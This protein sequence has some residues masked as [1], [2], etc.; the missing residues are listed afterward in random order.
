MNSMIGIINYILL[1]LHIPSDE[2]YDLNHQLQYLLDLP[3]D[4]QYE[5]NQHTRIKNYILL[6]LHVPSDEQY[7]NNH[8]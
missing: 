2:Q 5:Q 4:K 3:Y 1:D 8:Q 7:D 6:D